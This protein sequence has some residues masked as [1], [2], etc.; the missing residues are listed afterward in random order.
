[1]FE[2]EHLMIFNDSG[3]P[4]NASYAIETLSGTRT[5]VLHGRWHKDHNTDYIAA[6]ETLLLRLR[7]L[8]QTIIDVRVDTQ[9]T[10]RHGLSPEVCRLEPRNRS[11]PLMLRSE[12]DIR[13]LRLA[14]LANIGTTGLRPGAKG[15]HTP[16]KQI[17][18]Y[19]A[20]N[21]PTFDRLA[22]FLTHGRYE[23]PAF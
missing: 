17:R 7:Q 4:L 10:R 11:Y 2:R 12:A 23:A 9:Y 1:M 6:L 18:I 13:D 8:D 5:V 3:H 14:I 15:A 20:N 19:L 21:A 16:Y 22:R